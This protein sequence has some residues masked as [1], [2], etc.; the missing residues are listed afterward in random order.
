MARCTH[1]GRSFMAESLTTYAELYDRLM[2]R[3]RRKPCPACA[4]RHLMLRSTCDRLAHEC[5]HAIAC[6]DC[7]HVQ[8]I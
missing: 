3:S 1:C 5:V 4:G 7:G 2:T 8:S 6:A